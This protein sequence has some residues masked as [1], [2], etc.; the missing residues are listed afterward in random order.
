MIPRLCA[1]FCLSGVF[2]ACLPACPSSSLFPSRKRNNV[3]NSSSRSQGEEEDRDKEEEEKKKKERAK[4]N[5]KKDRI[6]EGRRER[7]RERKK[8]WGGGGAERTLYQVGL[9]KISLLPLVYSFTKTS[10]QS[11]QICII[12]QSYNSP[13]NRTYKH[14]IL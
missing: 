4:E 2:I 5:K 6:K 9:T 1:C 10:N 11:I 14:I 12:N 13:A 8:R 7:E 3:N